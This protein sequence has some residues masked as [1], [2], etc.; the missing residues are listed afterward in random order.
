M[1]SSRMCTAR[2]LTVSRGI[3]CMPPWQPCMPPTT[4]HA[5]R[6]HACPSTTTHSPQPP[7]TPPRPHT[8]L[9]N[10]EFPPSNHT[11]HPLPTT[12]VPLATTHA[13][14]QP[15]TSPPPCGQTDTCKNITFANILRA[16]IKGPL[17]LSCIHIER[18]RS[19][20]WNFPEPI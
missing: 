3:L 9:C 17:L 16:V 5:P 19:P 20:L 8:P 2:S 7:H 15:R 10:H 1:H 13:P 12:H 18:Q 6:N 11:C 4:T 14:C